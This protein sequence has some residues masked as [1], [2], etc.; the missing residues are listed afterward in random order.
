[1]PK[2]NEI[3]HVLSIVDGKTEEI[4]EVVE[5]KNFGLA[6]FCRQF[7]VDPKSD[8]KMLD[9][10]S[11][12]PDDASFLDKVLFKPVHFDFARFAYFVE[13]VRP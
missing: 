8:P 10:Y 5:F 3:L 7:D 2:N 6:D 12:G 13:A 1:M 4:V 9:R 11:V